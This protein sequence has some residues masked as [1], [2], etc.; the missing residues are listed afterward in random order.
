[1]PSKKRPPARTPEGRENQ[2]IAL[3]MDL[4]E[5]Q[6][7]EG[8]A[9]SQV[10]TH[11]LKLG[12]IKQQLE[13][14]KLREE[15]ALLKARTKSLESAERVE[16]LYKQAIEAMRMYSGAGSEEDEYDEDVY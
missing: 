1:M 7:A 9:S 11:F 13:N 15:N 6:I 14:E 5:K 3:A 10:L 2:V 12:S 4:A 16:E 8:T